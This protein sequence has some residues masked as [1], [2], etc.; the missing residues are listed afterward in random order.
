MGERPGI[1]DALIEWALLSGGDEGW[2]EARCL[3][4]YLAPKGAEILYLG[5]AWGVSVGDRW[6]REAK[7]N[8]WWDLEKQR[9]FLTHRAIIG[10][11]SLPLGRR[12]SHELLCDIE[13]L[14]IFKLQPWGNI[15]CCVTRTSR[16]G[17][18]VACAGDWPLRHSR[19]HDDGERKAA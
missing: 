3:Y 7:D 9:G 11:I 17:F 19:F 10:R 14:L 4:A 6:A 12:L 2:R 18:R 13:S 15:Q 16:P 1:T 5:K 8:F